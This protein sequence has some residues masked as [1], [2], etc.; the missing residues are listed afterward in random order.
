MGRDVS[1]FASRPD[2][3]GFFVWDSSFVFLLDVFTSMYLKELTWVVRSLFG[4]RGASRLFDSSVVLWSLVLVVFLSTCTDTIFT[5]PA[6]VVVSY[7][8]APVYSVS[9]VSV[10]I[11]SV[12]SSIASGALSRSATEA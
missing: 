3:W 2:E 1:S 12:Y 8:G 7:K 5:L 4:L 10:T 6:S 9:S 11:Y